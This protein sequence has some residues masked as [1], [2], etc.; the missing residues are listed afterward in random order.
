[1]TIQVNWRQSVSTVGTVVKYLAVPMLI[2][3]LVAVIYG[4]DIWV[5]GASILLVIVLGLALEQFGAG[6]DLH[7][8]EALLFVALSWLVVGV[9]GAVPFVLAGMGTASSARC[10]SSSPG[11]G[12][13]RPW[14]TRSTPCSSPCPDSRRPGRQLWARSVP[15]ATPTRC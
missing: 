3:L 4:E 1:M 10:R 2:P 6:D 7:P 15:T 14:R 9:V 12:R 8:R 13:R 5:F 11:W